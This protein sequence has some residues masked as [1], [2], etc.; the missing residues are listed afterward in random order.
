V[1]EENVRVRVEKLGKKDR[2]NRREKQR[3]NRRQVS[4]KREEREF[5]LTVRNNDL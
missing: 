2:K 1:K 3:K 4:G 5:L